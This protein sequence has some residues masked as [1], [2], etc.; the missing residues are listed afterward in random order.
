M[1]PS[2]NSV[3]SK[4]QSLVE[5]VNN[6]ENLLLL[7]ERYHTLERDINIAANK[8]ISDFLE[9]LN[10][11]NYKDIAEY[12][13][14]AEDMF[15][16]V[17]GVLELFNTTINVGDYQL[18]VNL[19]YNHYRI[20]GEYEFNDDDPNNLI[21]SDKITIYI[22]YDE[23]KD[24]IDHK[25]N[26]SQLKNAVA[27]LLL[28]KKLDITHEITHFFQVIKRKFNYK[29][30]LIHDKFSS[31]YFTSNKCADRIKDFLYI[32]ESNE[33]SARIN[34]A[35][36][37]YDRKGLPFSYRLKHTKKLFNCILYIFIKLFGFRE[38][39][40]EIL[41]NKLTLNEAFNIIND[42][43]PDKFPIICFM[44]LWIL[45]CFLPQKSKLY[46]LAKEYW[47]TPNLQ[48]D[49]QIIELNKMNIFNFFNDISSN[50]FAKLENLTISKD[51]ESK[52]F[53]ITESN[54]PALQELS[55]TLTI[56]NKS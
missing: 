18:N 3:N 15:Q 9:H 52:L 2:S 5:K 13:I 54:L 25:D 42:K 8:V 23:I 22:V 1:N 46:K 24:L 37:I 16:R 29:E 11:S 56:N 14:T 48:F 43:N 45:Y 50:L 17:K 28:N 35:K 30:F 40:D 26:S 27:R 6:Y 55:K 34:E 4:V 41:A 39:A 19:L 32:I 10:L 36:N 47:Q 31:V 38:E 21:P 7:L 53:S 20:T 33:V 12:L 44:I 49:P 51:L